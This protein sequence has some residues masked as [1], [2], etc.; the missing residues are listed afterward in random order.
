MS[1]SERV[2]FCNE[3]EGW[4]IQLASLAPQEAAGPQRY[5]KTRQFIRSIRR[6]KIIRAGNTKNEKLS[7]EG[8]LGKKKKEGSW[9]SQ[10]PKSVVWA[11][12]LTKH[13]YKKER[14]HEKNKGF[15]ENAPFS[16]S[17]FVLGRDLPSFLPS[18]HLPLFFPAYKQVP[19]LAAFICRGASCACFP[20]ISPSS[21]LPLLPL[22]TRN[23]FL[24]RSGRWI[25]PIWPHT[26]SSSH[27][28]MM[29]SILQMPQG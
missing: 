22:S 7:M 28:G 24:D 17:H 21:P 1:S 5:E 2:V 27:P 4:E 3:W 26:G 18:L 10:K 19:S 14:A 23:A 13:L 16:F 9:K 29:L 11:V 8:N 6:E 20:F 12:R 25:G 15:G